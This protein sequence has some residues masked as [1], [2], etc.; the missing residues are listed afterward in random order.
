MSKPLHSIVYATRSGGA[1]LDRDSFGGNPF[2]TALIELSVRPGLN[3]TRLLPALRRLTYEKSAKEQTPAWDALPSNCD[4][5]FPLAAGT[6]WERRIALVLVVSEYPSFARLAGAAHDERRIAS[7]LAGHGFSVIQGVPPDRRS[8]VKALQSFA[9]KSRG[10]DVA[11]I[12]STGHGVELGGQVFLLPG[13][14]PLQHGFRASELR[15]R[16]IPVSQIAAAC[17]AGNVNLTFFAGCR[18]EVRDHSA[19]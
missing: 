1:T 6:R 19:R 11:L 17:K 5:A 16:G 8:L 3:L 10:F 14:Y 15:R 18:T 13:T 7:M 9:I 12:Y 2:A 4:W